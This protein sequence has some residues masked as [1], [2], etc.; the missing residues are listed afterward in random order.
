MK[1]KDNGVTIELTREE[2]KALYDLFYLTAT[3]RLDFDG[4]GFDMCNQG[5]I[6][7]MYNQLYETF[8]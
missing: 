3:K 8:E 1:I 6:K 5:I 2:F 4:T 7:N